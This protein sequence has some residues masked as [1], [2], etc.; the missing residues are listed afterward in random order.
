M[1]L[2]WNIKT[3]NFEFWLESPSNFPFKLYD[4]LIII[5]LQILILYNIFHLETTE[6]HY[7]QKTL[8]FIKLPI[9]KITVLTSPITGYMGL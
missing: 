8:F 7:W 4:Y 6:K 2:L 3:L 1:Y 9:P 5:A